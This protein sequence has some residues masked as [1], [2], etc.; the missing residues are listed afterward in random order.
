MPSAPAR[1]HS[2]DL[3]LCGHHYRSSLAALNAAGALIE[4]IGDAGSEFL[5]ELADTVPASTVAS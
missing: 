4:S 5:Q 1:P 2:V 3:W